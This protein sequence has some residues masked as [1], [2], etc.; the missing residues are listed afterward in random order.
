MVTILQCNREDIKCELAEIY[1]EILAEAQITAEAKAKELLL[2][3]DEVASTLKV[4]PTTLWRWAKTKY[5][6]PI[7]MGGKKRY[8]SSDIMAIIN[9]GG[10]G[11]GC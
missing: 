8:K 11:N 7:Y 10:Q 3:P 1:K 6:N 5:L 9:N 4:S 2:T